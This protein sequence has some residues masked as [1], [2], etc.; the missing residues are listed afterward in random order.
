MVVEEAV[1]RKFTSDGQ[2]SDM[3]YMSRG[4]TNRVQRS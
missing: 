1:S 3:C 4:L 2:C